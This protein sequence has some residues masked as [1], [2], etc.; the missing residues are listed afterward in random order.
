[1]EI[2]QLLYVYRFI[3]AYCTL[4]NI[5]T[6]YIKR[7]THTNTMQSDIQVQCMYTA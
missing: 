4:N 6:V 1:M 2:T 5:H 3:F 7:N